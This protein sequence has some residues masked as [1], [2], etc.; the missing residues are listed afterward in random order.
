M[1]IDVREVLE[2]LNFTMKVTWLS[3]KVSNIFCEYLDPEN[4]IPDTEIRFL[5]QLVP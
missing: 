3:E 1:A 5:S 4:A 2:V